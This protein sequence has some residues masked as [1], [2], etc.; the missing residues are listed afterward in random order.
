MFFLPVCLF[1]FCIRTVW[2]DLKYKITNFALVVKEKK[3]STK[4]GAQ[5]KVE[6]NKTKSPEELGPCCSRFD[7]SEGGYEEVREGRL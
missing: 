7:H 2:F 3:I 5:A 6:L 1:K 4:S